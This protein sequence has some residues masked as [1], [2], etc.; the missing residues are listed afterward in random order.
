M[1]KDGDVMDGRPRTL[2]EDDVPDA[3]LAFFG[4]GLWQEDALCAQATLAEEDPQ[5]QGEVADAWFSTKSRKAKELCQIC[6]VKADCLELALT[7]SPYSGI[8]AGY[9]V[10]EINQIRKLRTP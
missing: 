4:V 3:L 9:T 1:W 2:R 8:W 5:A 10:R 6:P 7:I